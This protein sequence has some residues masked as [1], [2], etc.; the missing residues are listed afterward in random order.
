M[1][2]INII[3]WAGKAFHKDYTERRM[4]RTLQIYKNANGE[5]Y[6]QYS[7]QIAFAKQAL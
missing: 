2:S 6:L 7:F 3:W 5:N 4:I 1:F